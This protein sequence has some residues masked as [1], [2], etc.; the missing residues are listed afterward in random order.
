MTSPRAWVAVWLLAVLAGC[1]SPAAPPDKPSGSLPGLDPPCPVDATTEPG[2]GDVDDFHYQLQG[3]DDPGA[4]IADIAATAYDLVVIDYSAHGDAES[5]FSRED[6]SALKGHGTDQPKKVLAYLSIGEAEEY[7]FYW[8]EEW[9]A[10]HDG[11]PDDT[12]PHWLG[13]ANPDWPGDYK[14]RYWEPGWKAILFGGP[15]SY[16]DRILA[17]CFDGVYL[18][19]VDAYYYW[20]EEVGE[21]SE[22][23]ARRRMAELVTEIG[24]YAR[25]VG[26][27]PDYGVFPQNAPELHSEAG[28]VQV[29][30]GIG[31]EDLWYIDGAARTGE[32]L[33]WLLE[34]IRPFR[35]AGRTVLTID[36]FE[37]GATVAGAYDASRGEGFVPLVTTME[38]D[39]LRL[40][41]GYEPD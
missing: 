18:D 31:I 25:T 15:G 19:I 13:P 23:A 37:Q 27:R 39:R 30:T 9:D 14:V 3:Y 17:Q 33:E 6:V 16:L 10:D 41:A 2:W 20:S 11:E 38:L 28:Y 21:I 32:E 35:A 26:A 29:V 22:A 36:Y 24:L 8:E 5:E 34:N 7:R 12:A 40:H 4:G 1:F